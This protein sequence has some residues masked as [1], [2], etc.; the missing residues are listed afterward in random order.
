MVGVVS[1]FA[2]FARRLLSLPSGSKSVLGVSLGRASLNARPKNISAADG[3]SARG[4]P[5]SCCMAFS[6]SLLFTFLSMA[7]TDLT[8]ASAMPFELGK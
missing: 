6:R 1:T 3:P 4:V 8:A 5:R 2:S 7:F